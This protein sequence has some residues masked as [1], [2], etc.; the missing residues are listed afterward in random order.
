MAEPDYLLVKQDFFAEIN[1][2]YSVKRGEV[3]PLNISVFNYVEQDLPIRINLLTDNEEIEAAITQ[4]DI[5]VKANNNRVESL[6]VSALMLGEV[7]V[8]VKATID[9]RGSGCSKVENGQ[10]FSDALVK[11]LRVKTVGRR[12]GLVMF[13]FK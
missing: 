1:L 12:V 8:T 3:F 4:V 11:P 2:P 5:C 6:K 9:N 13:D 7:N 10:G